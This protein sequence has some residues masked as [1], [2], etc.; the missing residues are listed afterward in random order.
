MSQVP[1]GEPEPCLH[2]VRGAIVLRGL[3]FLC[4]HCHGSGLRYP[5]GGDFVYAGNERPIG[6]LDWDDND[7]T[8]LR[9]SVIPG[10]E[11]L[12]PPELPKE[13]P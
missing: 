5:I 10:R 11:H 7:E 3:T 2:C 8:V 4:P 13:H 1:P 12:L 6:N 9:P